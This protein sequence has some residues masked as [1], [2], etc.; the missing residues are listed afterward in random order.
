MFKKILFIT[1]TLLSSSSYAQ[2][3]YEEYKDKMTDEKIKIAY[4]E[5]LESQ[6]IGAIFKS[7][8]QMVI[9]MR[10]YPEKGVAAGITFQGGKN[11]DQYYYTCSF[12]YGQPCTVLVR[13]DDDK[14]ENF[15]IK[16]PESMDESLM[17]F[18]ESSRFY[19]RL[20]KAKKLK[21]SASFQSVGD[22]VYE[23]D[24]SN[25]DYKI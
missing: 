23:F 9:F 18:Y 17:Y 20:K 22:V 5:S 13:F 21:V 14:A 25:L 8:Y 11:H 6:A 1:L 3:E 4:N 16:P 24:V 19:E 2:W 15:I 10:N 7:R 12:Q